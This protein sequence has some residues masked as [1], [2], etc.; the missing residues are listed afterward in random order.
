M[1]KPG[2]ATERAPAPQAG[3]GSDSENG[4]SPLAARFPDVAG[5]QQS[6]AHL[7]GSAKALA[8]G[9]AARCAARPVVI[10]AQDTLHANR[11]Q[12]QLCFYYVGDEGLVVQGFPGWEVLPYDHFSPYHDIVSERLA[13]LSVLP[14]LQRGVVVASVQTLMQRL[15]PPSYIRSNS[16]V[17]E[18]GQAIDRE[19]F[20]KELESSGYRCVPEVAEH[21]DFAARGSLLDIFPVG[22]EVP[23][24]IDLLDDEIDSIRAFDP[25]TQ[26]SQ[27]LVPRVRVLPAHEFPLTKEGI[28]RFRS[29]WRVR[30]SGRPLDAPV[31]RDVSAALAPAGVESYLP[32]FFEQTATLF[33]YLSEDAVMVLDEGVEPAMERFWEEIQARYQSRCHDP[34]RPLLEPHALFSCPDELLLRIAQH[35]VVRLSGVQENSAQQVFSTRSPPQI[36]VDAR[37]QD[38]LAVLKRFLDTYSGRVL[39]VAE[40][41]GRRETLLEL[42]SRHGLRPQPVQA[43]H[44]FLNQDPRLCVTV[45]PLDEGALME[46]PTLAVITEAQLFG[47]RAAQRR[48]RRRG[49]EPEALLRDLTALHPGAPVV[50][51]E[52]GVGRYGGLVSLETGGLLGEYLQLDY[53]DGDKLYLP[54][55]SL[56]LLTRYSGVDPDHAPLHKL[57]SGQW[58]RAREKAAKRIRDVAAEL[59]EIHSRRAAR[60]GN[61]FFV[62]PD[63]YAGFVQGFPFEET[64]DQEAAIATVLQDMHAE[65][66]MDR[67]VCGDAGFGKTE[68]AL[69]AAFVAI[70]NGQQVAVLVPTTLLAQ[71]HF[72][73]FKDRFSDWPVRVEQLSRFLNKSEQQPVIQGIREGTVDIVIG[74]HKLLQQDIGFKR[75]GLLIIDEEHRFGVRQKER[76]KALRAQVDILTLS[77]TPI[78]RS[79]NMALSGVRELS[80]IA[81][82]PARRLAVKTF[83][84]EWNDNL[85]REALWREVSR[86]GQVYVLHNEVKSIERMAKKIASLVPE[87]SV[88]IAHGQMAE[89][90][91]ERIMLDF[92]HGRFNVLVC[93]TIIESGI[94]VPSANTLIVNRADKFGLAQLY[95]LRGRVGRS[96]HRAYAYLIVPS[97]KGLAG[98][99]RRRLEA[100]ESMEELGIGFTI[101]AHDLEIRGAGEILGEE[102]S[103]H[104]Q[105]IGFALYTELLERAVCALRSGQLP[106]L[107]RPADRNTEVDLR[108]PALLPEDYLPDAHMRLTFY[109]RIDSVKNPQDLAD[110]KEEVIDRFGILPPFADNL[111]RI[112]G[113]KLRAAWLG[114][115]RIEFGAEGG[116]VKFADEPN[117]DP[118]TVIELV[119]TRP[120]EYRLEGGEKLRIVKAMPDGDARLRTLSDLLE[121]FEAGLKRNYTGGTPRPEACWRLSSALRGSR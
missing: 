41:K 5:E 78:P 60:T 20:R 119:Q 15:A 42:L 14:S 81:T 46:Q 67:L 66:P 10:I 37:A 18:A 57:G 54:I 4:L 7:Y 110:L 117:I 38:P 103:G 50:H 65:A 93:T 58:Q 44:E 88:R 21:G 33:D 28:A 73:T 108:L 51:E 35:P 56:H 100:I 11:L 6:W 99:A 98:D 114:I 48:R 29:A 43:W 9:A 62:E 71:Q 23:Y 53:A 49:R 112:T 89:R 19:T 95:Q 34:E 40:T 70:N 92:Y 3:T 75:L 55:S 52:H 120:Q 76:L 69:R 121:I 97:I 91:L 87:A 22:G 116:R 17:L 25:E 80:L 79:L 77:A 115:R 102:Q 83:V 13:T 84:R 32:L 61:S 30:F 106:D 36:P 45:M 111:F 39:L 101:A 96:H 90:D 63:A 24:R 27:E 8:L 68:V 113:L 105:A 16:L 1:G 72:Q 118:G 109:K 47:D 12:E 82:P 64:P 107:E 26:R 2:S 85:L 86:G 59:L 31:Y 94:D 104:I 74:T